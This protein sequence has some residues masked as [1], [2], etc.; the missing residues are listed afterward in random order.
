MVIS[1]NIENLKNDLSKKLD[2][3]N[4]IRFGDDHKSQNKNAIEQETIDIID[5]SIIN[6]ADINQEEINDQLENLIENNIIEEKEETLSSEEKTSANIKSTRGNISE[7][8][9][10]TNFFGR[11][12]RR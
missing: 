12:R 11:S 1:Q 8:K 5:N 9:F 10:S 7:S 3:F 2:L 6:H 4:K